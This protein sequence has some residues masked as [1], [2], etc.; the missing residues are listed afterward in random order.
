MPKSVAV[1]LHC[2]ALSCFPKVESENFNYL[3]LTSSC[4]TRA[5]FAREAPVTRAT[6]RF[7]P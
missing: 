7:G 6:G 3:V 1:H 2:P 4:F 5:S